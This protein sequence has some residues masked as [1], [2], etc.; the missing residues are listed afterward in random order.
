MS[1][2]PDT[3]VLAWL[4]DDFTGAAAVMEVFAFADLPAVLFLDTPSPERM[5][6]FPRMQGIGIA[7]MARTYSPAR[8]ERDLPAQFELLAQTGARL[9]QYKTC[10]TL[11]SAPHV[12]SIGKAMD[13]GAAI[14]G[15]TTIPIM[16]AAPEMRRYQA[17]GTLFAGTDA[18]VFRLDR[19]PVMTRHPVTPMDEADVALHLAQQTDIVIQCLDLETLAEPSRACAM[20]KAGKG[21]VTID[22]MG[23][24]D[25]RAA[26]AL[27][28][29][30]H[31]RFVVG[32]QGIAYALVAHFQK[33]G[34]LQHAPTVSG[35]GRAE[36]MAVVSGSVS[37]TT[38]DQITWALD[39]G[40]ADIRLD[41]TQVCGGDLA[42]AEAR[43]LELA[44][45]SLVHG[46][47]PIIYTARGPDDPA[48]AQLRA[49]AGDQ[50]VQVNDDIGAA[51]G[52][53]LEQLVDKAGLDRAVV[54][55]GDTSGHVCKALG[56]DA[57]TAAAPTIPGAAI[58]NAHG[59]A[60]P[61]TLA[62]K[63]GQM[64][65]RDY[66]GWVLDGGGER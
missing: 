6:D 33:I 30:G 64:G 3:P 12:G 45:Q 55:G 43:A 47:V 39:N 16:I 57:L 15:A 21:G 59:R 9:V 2:L 52:R 60:S 23:P 41:V 14:F 17:F 65:S 56:I 31:N 26:G 50:L 29:N 58:C 19:H 44:L 25:V 53:I 28:W 37:S 35:I 54:S 62:L 22:Q 42:N 27:L 51:L 10:S 36:R 46:Q 18:G 49:A 7:S 61:L 34:L 5:A 24:Q 11:D 63:G 48:V 38:A 32:S 1:A 8:M 20:L 13:I 40:F 66:F 4:G